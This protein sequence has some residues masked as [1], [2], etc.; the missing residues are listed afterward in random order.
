MRELCGDPMK[1]MMLREKGVDSVAD[2][3]P[4][5]RKVGR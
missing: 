4:T 2:S 1:I 3:P 5:R